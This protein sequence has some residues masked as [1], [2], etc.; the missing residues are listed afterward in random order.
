MTYDELI[1]V[2][3]VPFG[4]P[5]G[6][7]DRV[8]GICNAFQ[9]KGVRCTV[10][11][12]GRRDESI[13]IDKV[14]VLRTSVP[15]FGSALS[16]RGGA[17]IIAHLLFLVKAFPKVLRMCLQSRCLVLIEQIVG[18]PIMLSMLL[19]GFSKRV[20]LD[21]L[22]LLHGAYT[23]AP[24]PLLVMVD[25]LSLLGPGPISTASSATVAFARRWKPNK[26]VL[27]TPNGVE[28]SR[29]DQT[30][31]T[32][33]ARR[34][35]FVG[36]LSFEQNRVAVG[37]VIRIAEEVRRQ[38]GDFT[39]EI[40]GGPISAAPSFQ[41]ETVREL[42]KFHGFIS[43]SE[44]DRLTRECAI[45]ILP[46][47]DDT[48]LTGGQ[49][50][51]AMRFMAAGLLVVSGP[52]G[53]GRIRGIRPGVDYLEARTPHEFAELLA[54]AI[55][56]FERFR[57]VAARGKESVEMFYSWDETVKPLIRHF[58]GRPDCEA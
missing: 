43:D 29:R 9:R 23:F 28:V 32:G 25:M 53:V 30:S 33:S 48:L 6:L 15:F 51:K 7:A 50:T 26:Q 31:T 55:N 20:V 27:F 49:R 39:I 56:D 14:K 18:L 10:I 13:D 46:F 17:K 58:F 57:A 41:S 4:A 12:P 34:L 8:R 45:G 5:H 54:C 1:L 11:C 35:L 37:H 52:Q 22:N 47:F 21:D 19:L 16:L 3:Y 44:L 24:R 36:N 38:A 42:V 40:V 2:S